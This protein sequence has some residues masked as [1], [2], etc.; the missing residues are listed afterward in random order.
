MRPG[1]S[2]SRADLLQAHWRDEREK[3]DSLGICRGR[4]EMTEDERRER[5]RKTLVLGLCCLLPSVLA[6]FR[7]REVKGP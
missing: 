5:K 2:S 7:S 6:D 3:R 1:S 4:N